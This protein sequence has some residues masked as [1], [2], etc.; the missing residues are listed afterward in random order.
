MPKTYAIKKARHHLTDLKTGWRPQG[1]FLRQ[2]Q[3]KFTPAAPLGKRD[4]LDPKQKEVTEKSITPFKKWRPQG[5]FLRQAQ[6]KFTPD[7]PLGK[8]GSPRLSRLESG[9]SWTPAERDVRFA[10]TGWLR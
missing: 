8:R 10:T 6:D 1:D 2:A 3:D 5:D 4:G 9:M 7:V